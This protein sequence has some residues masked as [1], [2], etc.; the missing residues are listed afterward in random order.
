MHSCYETAAV[1]DIGH[2]VNAMTAFYNATLE[3]TH[4][5]G[6]IIR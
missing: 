4:D 2:L 1:A 3:V 6:C 5:G